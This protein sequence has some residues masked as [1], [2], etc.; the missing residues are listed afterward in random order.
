MQIIEYNQLSDSQKAKILCRPAQ[1]QAD[2]IAQAVSDI[3]QRVLQ[4]G[5]TALFE[6]AKKFDKVDL[7]SL[8]VSSDK[9]DRACQQIDSDLKSAI[10]MAFDNIYVFHHAQKS[11]GVDIHTMAGVRCQLINRPIESVGL[12]VP[13]GSA[14]LFST[15]LMLAVPAKIAGCQR[16]VLCT[17]A[18]VSDVVLYTAK[19]CGIETVYAIGGAQAVFAM[20]YG[21]QS[22]AKVDKIFGPGNAYVTE[23]KRQ[24]SMDGVAI[25]MPAGPSELLVIADESANADFVASDLLSQAEHGADSQVVL[26]TPSR[27][28]AKQ[29]NTALQK[30]L[31]T[32]ARQHIAT[33]SLAHSHIIIASDVAQCVAI[34]NAYAPEHLIVQTQNP[35][36]LLPDIV[37]AGSVFLGAFSPESMGDYASGTNHTL[38]TYG[39]ARTVSSLSLADF[40]K[41]MTVQELS[42]DGF[43]GLANSVALMATHEGLDAHKLAVQ[44]RQ[45]YLHTKASGQ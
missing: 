35:R 4:D 21:T 28:L 17:P 45:A 31:P 8:Q 13:A 26:V 6:L 40:C 33:A 7:T 41:R 16:V 42:I 25:D 19:K 11:N 44:V 37:H 34:S 43:V 27:T 20:A 10:D 18:P 29:V 5:D 12:Y 36:R 2:N 23:A 15:V 39:Y 38:P 32:L 24:V 1:T 14:P 3:K 22:V 30:F 9:I